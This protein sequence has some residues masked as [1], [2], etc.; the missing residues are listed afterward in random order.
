[1]EQANL[2]ALCASCDSRSS[3]TYAKEVGSL[4]IQCDPGEGYRALY[5]EPAPMA[6]CQQP[7][8]RPKALSGREVLLASASR[9]LIGLCVNCENRPGCGL[10][11]RSG[12]VW[13]C[14][15]YR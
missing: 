3:C 9:G 15:E 5:L 10:M 11:K 14:E 6:H 12:G 2:Q 7:D 8:P 1:M 4:V 13:H